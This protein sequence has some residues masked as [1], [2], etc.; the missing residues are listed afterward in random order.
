MTHFAKDEIKAGIFMIKDAGL[1][2]FIG[3]SEPVRYGS[4]PKV[5]LSE[6]NQRLEAARL[7]LAEIARAV[8]AAKR[9]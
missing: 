7:R 5:S 9:Q 6:I 2:I 8:G 4:K 1:P 3:K